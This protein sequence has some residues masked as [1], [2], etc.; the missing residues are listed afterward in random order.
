MAYPEGPWRVLDELTRVADK[1]HQSL[2]FEYVIV[3]STLGEVARVPNVSK[4]ELTISE[5]ARDTARLIAAAPELLRACQ[6]LCAL[7]DQ[8]V[9]DADTR[10][11]Q[12]RT[13]MRTAIA[14]A[15]GK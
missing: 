14:R 13:D 9:N 7:E 5:R 8:E 1:A 3:G 12:V 4:E 10:W 6:L 15:L 2:F 11:K